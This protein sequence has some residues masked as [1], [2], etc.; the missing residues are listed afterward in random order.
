MSSQN[1]CASSARSCELSVGSE[2]SFYSVK[3]LRLDNCLPSGPRY[4][5]LVTAVAAAGVLS[6]R[7]SAVV[8]KK[9]LRRYSGCPEQQELCSFR[10]LEI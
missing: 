2:M 3:E 8:D 6:R 7:K 1:V 4:I 5:N 9:R 10:Y